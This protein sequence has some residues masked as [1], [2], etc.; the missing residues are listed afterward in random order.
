METFDLVRPADADRAAFAIARGSIVGHAFGNFYVITTRPEADIVRGVN[1]MKGRPAD[2]VGSLTTTRCRVAGLFDWSRLPEGLPRSSVNA[3][4]ERLYS[5]GPFGFRGPAAAHI[6]DHLAAYDGDIRTTQV[7]APGYACP[8]N[9]LLRRAMELIDAEFLYITSANRSRHVTGAEDEPAHFTAAGL[10]SEFGHE[11]NFV[12]VR[13][14]DEAAARAEYPLHAPMSTTILA[15]H[16]LGTPDQHGRPRLIVERHGSLP[17]AALAP[18]VSAYG[19]GLELGP[20][21]T[22]RLAQRVYDDV[23]LAA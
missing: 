12:V 8:S 2:Q 20:K 18:I 9:T 16:R 23:A 22:Q 1:L 21:A 19:F 5:L 14:R 4:I 13:H 6:P 17:I 11:P 7:I 15:F 10:E 3:L